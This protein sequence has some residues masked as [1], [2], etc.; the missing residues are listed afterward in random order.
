MSAAIILKIYGM[1]PSAFQRLEL[2]MGEWFH[3]NEKQ[4]N[5]T[6]TGNLSQ[7]FDFIMKVCIDNYFFPLINILKILLRSYCEKTSMAELI[8]KLQ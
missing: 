6:K 5:I 2:W 4:E 3:L 7:L 1:R 8:I